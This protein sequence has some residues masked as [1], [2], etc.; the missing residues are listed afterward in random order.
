[1]KRLLYN[2]AFWIGYTIV[3]EDTLVDW[4]KWEIK[5]Y[6]HIVVYKYYGRFKHDNSIKLKRVWALKIR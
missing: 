5:K 4:E 2:I 3:I 1:M 6:T